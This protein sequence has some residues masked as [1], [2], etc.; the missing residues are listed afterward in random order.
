MLEL[1]EKLLNDVRNISHNSSIV[2]GYKER[3]KIERTLFI[4]LRT[5]SQLTIKY[6][7]SGFTNFYK[8]E[9]LK[10]LKQDKINENLEFV[11]TKIFDLKY[12]LQSLSSESA[13]VRAD[14][15][16][17]IGVDKKKVFIIIESQI[18]GIQTIVLSSV[19]INNQLVQLLSP[20]KKLSNSIFLSIPVPA[21]ISSLFDPIR[22]KNSN[23]KNITWVPKENY[24]ITL[25]FFG[26]IETELIP[27]IQVALQKVLKEISPFHL[28]LDDLDIVSIE[29]GEG[30][31]WMKL[32]ENAEFYN[33]STKIRKALEPFIRESIEY[34]KH[35]PHITLARINQTNIDSK[36]SHY[37]PK[38]DFSILVKNYELLESNENK[39]GVYYKKLFEFELK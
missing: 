38:G 20:T 15:I 7:V 2:F 31:L 28:F 33:C 17:K 12:F 10:R 29:K 37:S 3:M 21:E 13:Y 14:A 32:N 22:E 36:L 9:I 25:L 34:E 16:S 23:N 5:I 27:N 35:I 8:N 26:I 4:I 39:K 18:K 1:F 30:I 24:H 11:I 6:E 19:K